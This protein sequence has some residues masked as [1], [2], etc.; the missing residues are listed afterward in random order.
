MRIR[1]YTTYEV[2]GHENIL[3]TE[4]GQECAAPGEALRLG[5]HTEDFCVRMT[6]GKAAALGRRLLEVCKGDDGD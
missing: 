6:Y 4:Y 3:V 1:E 5:I 2:E